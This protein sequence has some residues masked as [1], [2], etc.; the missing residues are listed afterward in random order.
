MPRENGPWR[1]CRATQSS[2]IS[3][4]SFVEEFYYDHHSMDSPHVGFD[5]IMN[6]GQLA[7]RVGVG[8]DTIRYYEK[9]GVLPK[10][11][12]S[13]SGAGYRRYSDE[14]VARLE[15]IRRAKALGF[16]LA[17]IT[18]LLALSGNA[19]A[20]MS[21][22]TIAVRQHLQTV[23]NKLTE[24]DR[25]RAGLEALIEICPGQGE[26]KACPI[27]AALSKE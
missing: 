18:D 4:H 7:K 23:K 11:L 10:P 14:D 20:D 13:G 19:Q 16:S 6:V 25:I 12:R 27:L 8:I 5:K 1:A 26:V 24:L 17:E 15:F 3:L 2:H 9:Q 22:V 21:A